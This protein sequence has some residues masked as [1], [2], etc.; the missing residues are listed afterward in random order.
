MMRLAQVHGQRKEGMQ[1][2]RAVAP[3]RKDDGTLI[4][5]SGQRE[6]ERQ[7]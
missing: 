6:G 5:Q 3:G 1:A 4:L 2:W 7:P